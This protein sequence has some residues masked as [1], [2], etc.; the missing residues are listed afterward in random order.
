[1]SPRARYLRDRAD[2][3]SRWGDRILAERASGIGWP[4]LTR[5]PSCDTCGEEVPPRQWDRHHD[6]HRREADT[7]NKDMGE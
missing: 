6:E 7:Y 1:M 2:F 4:A 3:L 5:F